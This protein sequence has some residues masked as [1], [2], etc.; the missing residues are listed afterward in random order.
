MKALLVVGGRGWDVN[1]KQ[2]VGLSFL[3]IFGARSLASQLSMKEASLQQQ[4]PALS[5]EKPS[6][7]CPEQENLETWF[8]KLGS[9]RFEPEYAMSS[10][11]F[12]EAHVL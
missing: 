3:Y 1:R 2:I 9:P 6:N 11:T 8:E 5:Q 10:C 12:P 4:P 7:T